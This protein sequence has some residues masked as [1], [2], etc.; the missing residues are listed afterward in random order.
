MGHLFKG[1]RWAKSKTYTQLILK[2]YSMLLMSLIAQYYLL[3]CLS[4]LQGY[5]QFTAA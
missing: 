5:S 3:A 4:T 1:M 2:L